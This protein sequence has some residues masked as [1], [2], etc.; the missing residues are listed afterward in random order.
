MRQDSTQDL[1]LDKRTF[2]QPVG[3]FPEAQHREGRDAESGPDA[4]A[5]G[6]Q[7]LRL[8]RAAAG[9]T[10]RLGWRWPLIGMASTLAMALAGPALVMA[11]DGRATKWWYVFRLPPSTA[12]LGNWLL[13]YAGMIMLSVAWLAIGRRLRGVAPRHV[14]AVAVMWALPLVLGPPLF[15]RDIYSYAGQG[16][17]AHLHL[18]PYVYG[19]GVLGVWGHQP[20]ASAVAPVWR[21]TVAPYG[22]TFITLAAL[23]TGGAA[24]LVATVMDL[25]LFDLVGVGLIALCVPRL[26]RLG[27]ADEGR[28]AWLAVLSPLVLLS[29]VAAGHNDALMIGLV[30]AGVTLALER[31]P[32]LGV[33]LCALAATIKVPAAAG[34]V[35]IA[36]AW[37]RDQSDRASRVRVL[38]TAGLATAV[39]LVGATAASGLGW[40]WLSVG[41]LSTPGQV[42]VTVT[43]TTALGTALASALHAL[44]FGPSTTTMVSAFRVL[45]FLVA[46]VTGLYLLWRTRLQTL[47]FCLGVTLLAVVVA[48]PVTWPW[49]LLWGVSLL[50]AWPA[51]QR[52]KVLVVTMA[53][54]GFVVGPAGSSLF[55]PPA[56]PLVA[57]V[58]LGAGV[59]AW[60]SWRGA[61]DE[62]LVLGSL[63]RA[64]LDVRGWRI[65]NLTSPRQ[66]SE[67]PHDALVSD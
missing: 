30:L 12:Q 29:L 51:T 2:P 35:F 21:Y 43:P 64:P 34:V 23:V 4:E 20:L 65:S 19:P 63:A 53:A 10:G 66:G 17:L 5:L 46:G 8:R 25:R 60:R 26:A 37:A 24:N 57:V 50:A 58:V 31:R 28:A 55:G 48:G 62:Q 67:G 32:L 36:V 22:P 18:S 14:C 59:W 15:S 49:Y 3:P 47:V 38:A 44:G 1:N 11:S 7:G 27:G 9:L 16:L 56:A 41:S 61:V 40:G 45:G 13:F 6:P 54:F 52:S 39:V 42:V 33:V